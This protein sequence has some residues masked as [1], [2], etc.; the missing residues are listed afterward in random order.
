MQLSWYI[1]ISL[2]INSQCFLQINLL[3]ANKFKLID[4]NLPYCFSI[5]SSIEIKWTK[6]RIGFLIFGNNSGTNGL[7]KLIADSLIFKLQ[8]LAKVIKTLCI[9]SHFSNLLKLKI[10]NLS[11][12]LFIFLLLQTNC[13]LIFYLLPLIIAIYQY[14]LFSFLLTPCLNLK[15]SINHKNILLVLNSR[16]QLRSL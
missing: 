16:F 5:L 14:L 4:L 7:F 8:S 10:S 15:S 1:I 9:I 3:L 2:L 6:H 12:I 13:H 11:T